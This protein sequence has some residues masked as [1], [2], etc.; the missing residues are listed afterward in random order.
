MPIVENN[1]PTITGLT[2]IHLWHDDLSSCS[3]RVRTVL[4]EKDQEWE[5]HQLELLH[6]D[7]LAPEFLAINPKGLV[8]VLVHDGVLRTESVDIIDYLDTVFPTPT[9]RPSHAEGVAAM[10]SWLVA[11]EEAQYDLKVLSHEFLFRAA[12]K[13]SDQ[14]LATFEAD[15]KNDVLVGFIRAY[16]GADYLPAEMVTDCVNRTDAG[17]ALVDAALGDRN[18]LVG[19]GLSLA[20]IAWMPNVHRFELMDWPMERYPNLAAWHGRVKQLPSYDAGILDWEPRPA[21][22]MLTRFARQRGKAGYHVRNFGVL[23][24]K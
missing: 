5:S 18:W 22:I 6:G 16:H 19:D 8:P 4:A 24:E 20:D 21:R 23:A 11:A 14:D 12:R 15:V 13:I 9:L 2:G 17:F 7:N 10:M 3:Q 1:D